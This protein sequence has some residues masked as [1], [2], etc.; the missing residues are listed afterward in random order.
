MER[1]NRS[2]SNEQER[3][4]FKVEWVNMCGSLSKWE[5]A[6]KILQHLGEGSRPPDSLN[7]EVGIIDSSSVCQ[8]SLSRPV[9]NLINILR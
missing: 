8:C 6:S 7:G 9:A 5:E 3:V 2:R 4:R 1:V